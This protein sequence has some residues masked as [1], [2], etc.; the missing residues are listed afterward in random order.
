MTNLT[1][2]IQDQFPFITVVVYGNQ[3]YVGIVINQDNNV[4]S[5]YDYNILKS[6][7]HKRIFLELGEVWWWES[8]R[9]IPINIF[10]RKEM[11]PFI[12]SIKNFSSKDVTVL[13]GPV[14]NLHNIML[15]RV[16]RRSVQLIRKR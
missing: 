10:L 13:M 1:E 15:K 5:F 2:K 3:E 16:K 11:D 7:E 12:Y 9:L 4:M 8:N 6:E 14:V